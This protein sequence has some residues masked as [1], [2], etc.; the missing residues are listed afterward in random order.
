MPRTHRGARRLAILVA[1]IVAIAVVIAPTAS[2][3]PARAVISHVELFKA[4]N[5]SLVVTAWADLTGHLR[6]V[7]RPGDATARLTLRL[8][9]GAQSAVDQMRGDAPELRARAPE[10]D[11]HFGRAYAKL[12]Q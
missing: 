11:I 12:V 10:L 5:G 4:H 3:K 6:D 1:A 9:D 2:A 8:S 7:R